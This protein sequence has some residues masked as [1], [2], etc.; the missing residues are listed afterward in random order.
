MSLAMQL[1]L[2]ERARQ[3]SVE[4]WTPEHDDRH[5]DRSLAFAGGFY[6]YT[7]GP[8]TH[9]PANWPWDP[10]WWKP[11]DQVSNIIR[12]LALYLAESAR[13]QRAGN[14]DE[15]VSWGSLAERL[16]CSLLEPLLTDEVVAKLLAPGSFYAEFLRTSQEV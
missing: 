3:V 4:G 1:V 16:S 13:L 11:R 6:L 14:L 15:A 12:G 8:D 2:A 5:T 7:S 9:I 10:Q